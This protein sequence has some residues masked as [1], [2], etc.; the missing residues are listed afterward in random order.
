MEMQQFISSE[1]ETRPDPYMF[2]RILAV[3]QQRE[4][5][6][7]AP[8]YA[9]LLKPV[10]FVIVVLLTIFAGIGI[11][12]NYANQVAVSRDYD[13]EL[14]YLSDIHEN[15]YESELTEE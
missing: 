6:R 13:T 11:G 12:R 5:V 2:T 4:A 10:A 8:F 15:G 3:M 7:P 9:L 1:K 14:Y